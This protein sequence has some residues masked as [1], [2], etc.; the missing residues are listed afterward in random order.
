MYIEIRATVECTNC[1]T[2][3]EVE[4]TETV[5]GAGNSWDDRNVE[6]F[7]DRIGWEVDG[8]T[9]LCGSCVRDRNEEE[10]EGGEE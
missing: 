2:S 10:E 9:I 3:E 6:R 8:E 1:H 4:L 5:T 7:L